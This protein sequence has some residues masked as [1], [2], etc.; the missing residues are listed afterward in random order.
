MDI[1]NGDE[2]EG[3]DV[4]YKLDNDSF[5]WS[6]GVEGMQRIEVRRSEISLEIQE[7][8]VN[9]NSSFKKLD[10]TY[11]STEGAGIKIAVLDTGIYENHLLLS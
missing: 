3:I 6:G 11:K 8:L 9:F 10:N 2:Y 4:W 1:V 7:Q 5:V